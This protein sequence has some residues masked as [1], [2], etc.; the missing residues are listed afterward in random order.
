MIG[1]VNG[2]QFIR[3]GGYKNVLVIGGDVLSRYVDWRDRGTCIL[4]GDGAGACVLTATTADACS[5]K[6]FDMH[7]DGTQNHHLIAQYVGDKG[8]R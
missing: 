8:S 5:L 7:S 1:L 4:F 2:T 3:S 6:G